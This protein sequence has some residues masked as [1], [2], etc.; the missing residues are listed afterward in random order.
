MFFKDSD[1][2]PLPPAIPGQVFQSLA[3]PT[4]AGDK[5]QR[6]MFS[7]SCKAICVRLGLNLRSAMQSRMRGGAW[8]FPKVAAWHSGPGIGFLSN[9]PERVPDDG[10]HQ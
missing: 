1:P 4:S 9:V 10:I 5:A 7:V 3:F 6:G 8:S 2:V